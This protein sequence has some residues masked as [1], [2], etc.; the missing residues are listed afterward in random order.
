MLDLE[1]G[2]DYHQV[3]EWV[4]EE[5]S[6]WESDVTADF[7]SMAD[8]KM[9]EDGTQIAISG[10][11]G[12][13]LI[14]Y[15][16]GDVVVHGPVPA[17]HSVALLP[18]GRL[19]G[20]G[21]SSALIRLFEVG[22]SEEILWEDEMTA[23]HGVVWDRERE[24]LYIVGHDRMRQYTLEDWDTDTPTL[25]LAADLELPDRG[26]HDLSSV[27]STSLLLLST[28]ANVWSFDR[29]TEVF[30]PYAPLADDS[31]VKSV[32][33]HPLSGRVA[34]SRADRDW[35]TTQIRLLGPDASIELPEEERLYKVRWWQRATSAA[36]E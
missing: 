35:W 21:A 6:G 24:K 7:S 32:D 9:V 3:W 34:V 1:D 20:V 4:A 33:V 17:A 28:R 18:Q 11:G 26:A 36:L 2:D 23:A 31:K 14:D 27:A 8:C 30:A 13:A 29:E 25:A 22:R 15:P 16:S 19:V 12:V 5:A 10:R